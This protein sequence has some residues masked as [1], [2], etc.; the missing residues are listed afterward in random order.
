MAS[1]LLLSHL[2]YKLEPEKKW[3]EVRTKRQP[4][5]ENRRNANKQLELLVIA[6][7]KRGVGPAR[8]LSENAGSRGY[9][10]ILDDETIRK[11]RSLIE[12]PQ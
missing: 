12:L 2:D 10:F 11:V 8:L 5:D 4:D 6:L 7:E 1:K 9:K 3:F